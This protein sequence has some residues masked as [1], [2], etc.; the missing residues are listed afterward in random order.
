MPIL[1]RS[2]PLSAA[3]AESGEI[4]EFNDALRAER[5]RPAPV[6]AA[7]PPKAY[8]TLQALLDDPGHDRPLE[9]QLTVPVDALG[10]AIRVLA[11]QG[12]TDSAIQKN[13]GAQNIETVAKLRRH[14]RCESPT[15]DPEPEAA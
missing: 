9:N 13:I 2:Q 1:R 8:C 10:N 5:G 14:F 6:A 11:A 12:L 4:A 7:E 15:E 3:T